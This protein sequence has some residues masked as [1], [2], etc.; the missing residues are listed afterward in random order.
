M[1]IPTRASGPSPSA[2]GQIDGV[3]DGRERGID[4]S[5]V[6]AVA[7]RVAGAVVVEA[8]GRDATCGQGVGQHAE[9]VVRADVLTRERAGTG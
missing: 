5:G 9:G 2:L 6:V 7:G 8:D 1:R 3:A 4:P